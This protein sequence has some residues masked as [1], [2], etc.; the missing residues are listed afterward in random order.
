MTFPILGDT[1]NS[2]SYR[3]PYIRGSPYAKALKKNV[4]NYGDP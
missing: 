1:L 2:V 4:A 3:R